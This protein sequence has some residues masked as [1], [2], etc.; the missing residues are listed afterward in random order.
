MP[1]GQFYGDIYPYQI[2]QSCRCW[3]LSSSVSCYTSSVTFYYNEIVMSNLLVY[4]TRLRFFFISRY[5]GALHV[6]PLP[7]TIYLYSYI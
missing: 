1:T 3:L 2:I 7:G 5:G 4:L 6:L